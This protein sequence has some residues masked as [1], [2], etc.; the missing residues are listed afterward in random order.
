MVYEEDTPDRSRGRD[1]DSPVDLDAGPFS[2]LGVQAQLAADPAQSGLNSEESL[3][4]ARG[5]GGQQH[6]HPDQ[7][8]RN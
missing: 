8:P 1:G 5:A 7:F 4:M 2:G 3:R 6:S